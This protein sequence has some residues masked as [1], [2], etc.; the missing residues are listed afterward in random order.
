MTYNPHINSVAGQVLA[1]F[2][3]NP[4]EHLTLQDVADKFDAKPTSVSQLLRP[5]TKA[6]LLVYR[7]KA[8]RRHVVRD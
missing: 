1:F 2:E 3:R 5:A 4:E 8:Y 6:G 7:E